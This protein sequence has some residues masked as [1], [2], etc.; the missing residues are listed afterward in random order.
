MVVYAQIIAEPKNRSS[1]INMLPED[2]SQSEQKGN[3]IR[4]K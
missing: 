1:H 2:F 3:E 4:I